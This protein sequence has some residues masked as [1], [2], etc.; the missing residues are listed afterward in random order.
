MG[1]Q[2]RLR[3]LRP[4]VGLAP[5]HRRKPSKLSSDNLVRE[6]ERL[7]AALD[8]YFRLQ[9][10]E[11]VLVSLV[12]G[13]RK[14][15]NPA[16]LILLRSLMNENSA[17][18]QQLRQYIVDLAANKEQEFK[19]M[20][21]EA[22]RCREIISRPAAAPPK[23]KIGELISAM[24]FTCS[25]CEEESTRICIACTKDSCE[26]HLCEKCSRCSDCCGCEVA[27]ND[28]EHAVAAERHEPHQ[29]E[30]ASVGGPEPLLGAEPVL[31]PSGIPAED[32]P[33]EAPDIDFAG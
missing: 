10:L 24:P 14:Y 12:E 13:V 23:K 16:W 3:H 31:E 5:A 18:R 26:N 22:Q 15:Q 29:P 11:V 2:R 20:D 19:V 7:T 17:S 28:R 8:T 30:T 25:I 32:V 27:L 4:A 21:Q 33:G 6:P 9:N 1:R